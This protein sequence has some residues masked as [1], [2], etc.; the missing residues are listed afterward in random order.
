M[1]SVVYVYIF[2]EEPVVC[3]WPVGV[4]FGGAIGSSVSIVADNEMGDLGSILG[5]DRRL[6]L[7]SASRAFL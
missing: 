6:F 5:G 1:F 3:I 2:Y 7:A 4:L